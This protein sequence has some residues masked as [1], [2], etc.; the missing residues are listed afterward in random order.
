MAQEVFSVEQVA[1]KLG[2]HVR[3]VRNYVRD[4]RLK[5]VRIGK[6][7]RIAADDLEAFTGLPVADPRPARAAELSGVVEIGDVDRA[8]ADRIATLVVASV[9]GPRD[10]GERP[11]RVET[12]HDKE[13][14]TM[15]IVVFGDLAAGADL[16][17]LVASFTEGLA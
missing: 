4:G 1:A 14:S 17:R 15:K 2:L 11:L 13:R 9:N 5:A 10:G 8:T 12:I 3:T 16:L 6:Q 7:Y